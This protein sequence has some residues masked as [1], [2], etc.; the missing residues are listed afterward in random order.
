MSKPVKFLNLPVFLGPFLVVFPRLSKEKLDKSKLHGKNKG[1]SSQNC[2]ERKKKCSY[3][4]A[5]L[6]SIKKILKIKENF[7]QLLSRKIEE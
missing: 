7:P 3:A 1:N 5:L 2:S 6:G 4:Q